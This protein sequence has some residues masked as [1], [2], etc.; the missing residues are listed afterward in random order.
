MAGKGGGGRGFKGGVGGSTRG[1][2]YSQ[3]HQ[4]VRD[5]REEIK[6]FLG[7]YK[8]T[9]SVC[10]DL[11]QPEFFRR[12]PSWEEMAIFVSQQLCLTAP[13]KSSLKD[14]QL[15]PV[16]K[17]LFIKFR[18]T[19][20]RDNVA[21]K[22]KVGVDWPAFEA[23]V[24]GWAMDKPVIVV[25]LHGVSP[26]STKQEIQDVMAQYGDVL[27][28]DIG[29]ISKKLLPGVTNGT[30][31]VK[32]IL[33]EGKVLPSF[34][35][36]KEEGEVWQVTHENQTNVCWKCGQ[37]GHV[38]AR[39]N[40]P[41]LTF[42][43][44]DSGHH[45]QEEGDGGAGGI[46]SWAHVVRSGQSVQQ[47]DTSELNRQEQFLKEAKAKDI[48]ENEAAVKDIA[49]MEAAELRAST[50]AEAE[51]IAGIDAEAIA[52]AEAK[53]FTEKAAS[54][55]K[56]IRDIETERMAATEV[57]K[58]AEAERI[59]SIDD[60]VGEGAGVV[61]I[62]GERV[63]IVSLPG[64]SAGFSSGQPAVLP[65][66]QLAVNLPVELVGLPLAIQPE[67]AV[68][69][70]KEKKL[71]QRNKSDLK[72]VK[73]DHLGLASNSDMEGSEVSEEVS[74]QSSPSVM[75]ISAMSGCGSQATSKAGIPLDSQVDLSGNSQAT[76]K[77]GISQ[78]SGNNSDDDHDMFDDDGSKNLKKI[79]PDSSVDSSSD[80]SPR[81]HKQASGHTDVEVIGLPNNERSLF[82]RGW[83]ASLAENDNKNASEETDKL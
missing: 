53:A 14:I 39:C 11:Y 31:T 16:K 49:D 26:E 61:S 12:K 9:D 29:Y 40:Q 6:N 80:N 47:K 22:L 20:S 60:D 67:L 66:V 77:A 18:D 72:K 62:S 35:F 57:Q 74:L 69:R 30:W 28:I 83:N 2:G 51:R 70:K 42:S 37:A 13:L 38:D 25:R 36:M 64:Q 75:G 3:H 8:R 41:T 21:N 23:K 33:Q 27:D 7:F 56:K 55:A 15:H 79:V 1:G 76:S 81:H 65:H 46:R 43:A 24:H 58:I 78:L 4:N 73:V 68:K 10:I 32:M 71:R 45:I 17:H 48:A 34:V 5:K 50:I 63:Q 54:E 19:T 59:T 52:A 82:N 44:L